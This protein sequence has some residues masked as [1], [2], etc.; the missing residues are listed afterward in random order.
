MPTIRIAT[1]NIHKCIGLDRRYRPERIAKVLG[2]IDADI[3]A[4]QEVVNHSGEETARQAEL[5]SA[6]LGM[7]FRHGHNRLVNGGEYGNAILSRL[8]IE[9]HRNFDISVKKY[10]PRG[11]LRAEITVGKNTVLQFMNVHFGTSFFERRLQVHRLLGA[12]LM[13]QT[14]ISHRIIAGD[15]NEWTKG[16]ATKLLKAKFNSIEPKLHLGKTR[17]YPGILPMMHL[18]QIYFDDSFVLQRAWLHRSR[19]A[20]VASDHLPIVAEFGIPE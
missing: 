12:E 16:L 18:D 10:E 4:L 17:T 3:V 20:L 1:Y 5:I 15:F 19:T 8:P 7:E 11:C 2:E 13:D 14:A 9:E 6:D